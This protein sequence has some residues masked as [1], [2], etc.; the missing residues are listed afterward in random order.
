MR[1]QGKLIILTMVIAVIF[2]S[3]GLLYARRGVVNEANIEEQKGCMVI[4]VQFNFPVRYRRHF[5]KES[6][7]AVRIQFEPISMSSSDREDLFEREEVR[8]APDDRV[9]LAEVI[10][11]GNITGGPF[12]T[13]TFLRSICIRG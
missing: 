9:P 1:I 12:L 10:F 11:E 13:L 5:P 8:F 4:M 2:L 3:S 7:D 6:S